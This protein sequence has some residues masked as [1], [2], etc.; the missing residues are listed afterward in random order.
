MLSPVTLA[1]RTLREHE[2]TERRASQ[3]RMVALSLLRCGDE[4]DSRMS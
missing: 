1:E 3:R 2:A 4:R